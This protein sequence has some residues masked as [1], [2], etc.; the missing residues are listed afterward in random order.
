MSGGAVFV[1]PQRDTRPDDALLRGGDRRRDPSSWCPLCAG[2]ESRTPPAVLRIPAD[3]AVAWLARIIPNAFPV[4]GA[5][6]S[7]PDPGPG[8]GRA[9]RGVHDVIV[10]SARHD[11]S[12]LDIEPDAWGEV[13]ELCRRRL[14]DV[15]DHDD[16]CWGTVFKNAGVRAG[17]SLE[18]VHSQLVALDLV[19]PALRRELDATARDPGIFAGLLARARAEGRIVADHGSLV[20]L[21]PDAP[22]QPFET[23]ILPVAAEPHFHRTSAGNVR[24]LA[25]LTR[26]IVG[27]LAVAA[28]GSDYNWW[29]HDAPFPRAGT[30]PPPAWHW[31]LEIL[32][33]LTELAGFEL[34]TGWH[35]TT[36]TAVESARLLREAALVC[37]LWK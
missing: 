34:G 29:L 15:A 8:P 24:S 3:P 11:R 14:A 37:R 26:E 19:P 25:M 23:W 36:R 9:A 32:P 35:V 30:A 21:V 7:E 17:A 27:R 6:R 10:E 31:H 16:L 33:R 28:P 22:R 1:A 13:W 12:I 2:N 20:A 18:H 5:G 4:V